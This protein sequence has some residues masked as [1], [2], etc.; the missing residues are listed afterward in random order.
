MSRTVFHACLLLALAS[1]QAASAVAASVQSSLAVSLAS[2]YF[3]RGVSQSDHQPVLQSQLSLSH[4]SGWFG[5]LFASSLGEDEDRFGEY[6]GNV[7]VDAAVGYGRDVGAGWA[8]V[9]SASRYQ[10]LGGGGYGYDEVAVGLQ[11]SGLAASLAWSDRG[12]SYWGDGLIGELGLRRPLPR[13]LLL[14]TGIGWYHHAE[15]DGYAFWHAA[16]SRATRRF[17]YRLGYYGSDQQARRDF[18]DH[19]DGRL[20][21]SVSFRVW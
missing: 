16:V 15:H 17:D 4:P 8:V 1:S 21:A 9:G 11:R 5:S 19:A 18:G 3:V 20:V 7:E 12:D 13:R 10:Y 2:D 14:D 6:R